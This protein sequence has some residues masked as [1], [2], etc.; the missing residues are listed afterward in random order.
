MTVDVLEHHH[1]VV[2]HD[3]DGEH[4]REH[5]DVVQREAHVAHEG[6]GRDHRRGNRDARHH[7]AA[8]VADEEENGQRDQ[9]RA[10]PHVDADRLDR[11][12]DEPRL[13]ADAAHLDV[14]GQHRP[15]AVE[16]R[17]H[18]VDHLDGVRAGLLADDE[19]D[20][21]LAVQARERARLDHAVLRVA[22]VAH[23]ERAVAHVRDDQVVEVRDGL[24]ASHRPDHE[25]APGLIEAPARQL[26]VLALDRFAHLADRETLRRE[27]IRIHRDVDGALLPAEHDDLSDTGERL[28]VLL[29]LPARELGHLAQV[30]AARER[31]AHHRNRVHV[32]LVDHRRVRTDGQLRQDGR[33]LVAHVLRRG[34]ARLLEHELHD[35]GRQ[36]LLGNAA[37]LV[38]A[39]DRVD[40]LLEDLRDAG[41]HLLD[42]RALQRGGDRDDREVDVRKEVEPEAT[43]GEEAEH[44]QRHDQHGREHR[45]AD[46]DVG[47]AHAGLVRRR[48]RRRRAPR[49]ACRRRA[50]RARSSPPARRVRL[51]P[52]S[53][54]TR[55]RGRHRARPVARARPP[56]R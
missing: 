38:D 14:R 55:R 19:L 26:Q 3:A 51:L 13:V 23:P 27:A 32:E 29:H 9:D 10:E 40:R 21:V 46:E 7:R 49:P 50:W 47:E 56:L 20:G 42:A 5:G 25:L 24:D 45:A 35:D 53:R 11:R 54:P 30:P 37:E 1:G 44:D 36:A 41:L 8:P 12:L 52:R 33:H 48:A 15:E 34:V 18:P 39:V 17:L 16:L 2:D 6:E 22:E 28:D 43:V 31:D 4:E